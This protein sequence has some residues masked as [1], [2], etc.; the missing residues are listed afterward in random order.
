VPDYI[1][2]APPAIQEG[3]DE[4]LASGPESSSL[5]HQQ[6]ERLSQ[7]LKQELLAQQLQ[8][9]QVGLKHGKGCLPPW[10]SIGV[11][12]CQES[13]RERKAELTGLLRRTGGGESR[14]RAATEIG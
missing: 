9:A 12:G 5:T 4:A 7:Q 11:C 14:M 3:D 10:S 2:S 6:L 13:L 1:R 8:D